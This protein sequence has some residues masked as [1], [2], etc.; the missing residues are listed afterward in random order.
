VN[1]GYPPSNEMTGENFTDTRR[2]ARYPSYGNNSI[3]Q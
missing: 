3:N 1:P 2:R